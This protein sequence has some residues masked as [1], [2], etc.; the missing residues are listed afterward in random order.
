MLT[1]H[2]AHAT[3]G[4]ARGVDY[5]ASALALGA[6]LAGLD[7]AERCALC[8]HDRAGALTVGADL[9]GR[10]LGTAGALTVGAL[11]DLGDKGILLYAEG[12]LLKLYVDSCTQII[13]LAGC[14]GV[15]AATAAKAEAAAEDVAEDISEA[16]EALKAAEASAAAEALAGVKG[17]MAELVVLCPLIGVGEHLVCLVYLLEAS[18]AFLVAGMQVGV[19]F[20]GKLSVCFFQL[21]LRCALFDAENLIKISFF[22][23]KSTSNVGVQ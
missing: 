6:L 19:I 10:A 1:A 3:A 18:L 4:L 9:G 8:G 5:L 20:L 16:A 15:S 7:H 22:C 23:H 17:R 14:V 2:A 13:A 11:L 12:S 21:V